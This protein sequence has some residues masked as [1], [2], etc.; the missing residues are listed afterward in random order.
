MGLPD[1]FPWPSLTIIRERYISHYSCHI[2]SNANFHQVIHLER[3]LRCSNW[4]C[5]C[6]L[7]QIEVQSPPGTVVGYVKQVRIIFESKSFFNICYH[8][9]L[10]LR[11]S[12]VFSEQ[13]WRRHCSQNQRTLLF[14]SV[15]WGGIPGTCTASHIAVIL[16][17]VPSGVEQWRRSG[18]WKN[19]QKMVGPCKRIFHW[20]WQLWDNLLVV[21]PILTKYSLPI[22]QFQWILMLKWKL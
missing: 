2:C 7:Q 5:F 8:A 13:C 1:P 14:L 6:C 10:Q 17:L 16:P 20:C 22:H 18:S 3:P 11:L 4:C 9:G 19:K 21:I 15:F 12:L